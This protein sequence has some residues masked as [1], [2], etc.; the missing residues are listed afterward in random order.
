MNGMDDIAEDLRVVSDG[1]RFSILAI[2]LRH[3]I[4]SGAL[5]RRL[6]I[7]EAAVSQHMRVLREA[8]F[9]TPVRRGYFTHYEVDRDR[10]RMLA[11]ALEAMSLSDRAPCD[12]VLEGCDRK[13]RGSCRSAVPGA[14]CPRMEGGEP[15][16][17]GCR[18]CRTE[19]RSGIMRVAATYENGEVFQHFGR[20]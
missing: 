9:V 8:G 5:A 6:G 3:D 18:R 4:C 19:S 12:P 10:I 17:P 16:C 13:G 14:G 15:P 11:H 2:L 20:T 1:T 7:S